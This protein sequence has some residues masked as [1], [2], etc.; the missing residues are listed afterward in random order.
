MGP[1]PGL[2]AVLG[3]GQLGQL[4]GLVAVLGLVVVEQMPFEVHV[5]QLLEIAAEDAYVRTGRGAQVYNDT[6]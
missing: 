5:G 2:V 3:L 4:L 6:H 1:L